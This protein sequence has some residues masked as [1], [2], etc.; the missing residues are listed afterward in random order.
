MGGNG[1]AEK[2]CIRTRMMVMGQTGGDGDSGDSEVHLHF[3][4]F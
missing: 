2:A 3:S 4:V 1:A